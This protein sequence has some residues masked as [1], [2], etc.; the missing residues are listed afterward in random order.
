M[1]LVV[2]GDFEILAWRFCG[3]MLI[4][5]GNFGKWKKNNAIKCI[6]Q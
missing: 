5:G 1:K 2:D 3:K 4:Y 6:A